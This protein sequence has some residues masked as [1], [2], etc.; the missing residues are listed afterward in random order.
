MKDDRL[1]FIEDSDLEAENGDLKSLATERR[2]IVDSRPGHGSAKV[3]A[4]LKV[5]V[6]HHSR[7]QGLS[8]G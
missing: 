5:L 2:S 7:H 8:L 3:A 1:D 6:Y 4:D